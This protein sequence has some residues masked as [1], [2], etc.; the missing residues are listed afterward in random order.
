MSSENQV[1]RT[2]YNVFRGL[3]RWGFWTVAVAATVL[4][5]AAAFGAL[6]FKEVARDNRASLLLKVSQI[7]NGKLPSPGETWRAVTPKYVCKSDADVA[8]LI[9]SAD[10]SEDFKASFL[11][12][13]ISG[14][15]QRIE[16]GTHIRIVS[17]DERGVICVRTSGDIPCH[18]TTPVDMVPTEN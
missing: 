2:K 11:S 17:R 9:D 7:P 6:Q 8:Q 18:F 12:K 16:A 4:L 1:P 13:L 3:S 14:A 15:C 10:T 5:T